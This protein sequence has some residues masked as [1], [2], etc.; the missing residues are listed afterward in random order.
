MARLNIDTGILG[1]PA[2]GDTL[3]TAFGK[4]NDNFIEVFDDLSESGLGGRLTNET[5]NGD[6]VIQPNGTGIVEV[7]QLQITDDAITSLVTNSD[8][9]LS[10]N[11]TGNVH[12]NDGSLIVGVNDAN[13][14]ITT[15]GTGDLT[16]STNGGTNSGT[17]EIKDGANGDITIENDGTGDILLK[18]GGQVGIGSVSSPDTSLHVKT[19]AAKVTLQRTSDANTPGISFQQSGGNVRAELMM[20]GT[21]GTSNT[22]FV[23]THDGASLAERFRVTHTGAKVTGTLDVD[24][25]ISVTDNKITASRS[26]DNLEISASGTGSVKTDSNLHLHS[27][28]PIIQ[29]QRSDNANVPGISFLGDGGTEGGSIKFDGTSGTTNEIILSSFHSSAVTER[30]RVQTTGAKVTGILKIGDGS[31]TDNY[32]GFGN[33]DDLKIFHNG[34]HSII[35]ETGTGSLYLQ[36]DN[37]VII[38]KDSGSDTMIK[39]VADGAVELYHDNSKKFETTSGGVSVTG[40]LAADGSQIDFTS[41]PTSDPGVAGRLFR[42]GNDVKISTG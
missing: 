23:K 3:R 42:S 9:T 38:G 12:I 19:A 15:L 14:V 11:G 4:I 8:L 6:V 31:A 25:G 34:S 7:D 24:G 26:N 35:R 18:A 5:T 33:A 1:N 21:S 41:L 13:A 36:S 16:L 10:G 37:N 30:L 39:G 40:N 20:D 29:I 32:A 22:V 28:T 2:T 17:I 27:A